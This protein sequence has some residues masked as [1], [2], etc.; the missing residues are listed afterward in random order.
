MH[1][2]TLTPV[3]GAVGDVVLGD[4]SVVDGSVVDGSVVDGVT[5]TG[6]SPV[7]S[8]VVVVLEP[9]TGWTVVV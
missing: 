4:G 7:A 5:S 8:D 9:D 6:G 3:S 2:S 1:Y